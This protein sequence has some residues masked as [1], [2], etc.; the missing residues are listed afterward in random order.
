MSQRSPVLAAVRA[1]LAGVVSER[2]ADAVLSDEALAQVGAL[3]HA[4]PDPFADPEIL[5]AAGWFY[6]YRARSL[7]ANAG[8]QDMEA[9]L[10]FLMPVYEAQPDAVPNRLRAYLDAALSG[11]LG[12]DP[13]VHLG[14]LLLGQAA[15]ADRPGIL[16]K[17]IDLLRQAV[18]ATSSGHPER[19]RYLSVL[20][21]ALQRRFQRTGALADLDEAVDVGRQALAAAPPGHPYHVGFLSNLGNAL[22]ARFEHAG[23]HADLEEAVKLGRQAVA[24]MAP[25]DPNRASVMSN[26][27]GNLMPWFKQTGALADLD[28]AIATL[29]QAAAATPAG[30]A[31]MPGFLSNLGV[32]LQTRFEHTG[33]LADLDESIAALHRAAAVTPAGHPELAGCLSNFAGA[34]QAR[35]E[36]TGMPA[37][38]DDAIGSARQA[39]S[40]TPPGHANRGR[41]L[42]SLGTILMA[43]YER[44]GDLSDLNDAVAAF[45]QVT[46]TTAATQPDYASRVSKLGELLRTRFGRT[47]DL[48]DL[49]EAVSALRQAADATPHDHPDYVVR[50][51]NLAALLQ[52]RFREVGDM[53]DLHDTLDIARQA[54]AAAAP[55]HPERAAILSNFSSAMLASYERTGDPAELD[56]AIEAGRQAVAAPPDDPSDDDRFMPHS[57]LGNALRRRFERTGALTDLNEAIDS[58]RHAVETTPSDH[59]ERGGVLCNLG[60]I[61]ARRYER[62]GTLADLEEDIALVRQ[63]VAI[64]PPG[65]P[66]HPVVLSNLGVG[67]FAR[68]ERTEDVANLEEAVEVDRQA[69]AATPGGHLDRA[70][71][72]SSLGNALAA[73]FERTGRHADLDEAVEFGRQAVAA[74]P[75][76]HPDLTRYLANL[77]TS[78]WSRARNEQADADLDE[79]I[80]LAKLA[81]GA[82]DPGH[83]NRAAFLVNL[84]T[85]LEERFE[86]TQDDADLE[87]AIKVSSE[88]AKTAAAPPHIRARAA[89]TWGRAAA[90]GGR[91]AEAADGFATAVELLA[92]VAP[93]SLSRS[94]QEYWLAEL[95]GLGRQAAACCLQAGQTDRAVELWEQGRGILIAQTLETR[96]DLTRLA[97]Q[98]PQLAAEFIGLRDSLDRPAGIEVQMT[99]PFPDIAEP[100]PEPSGLSRE[101]DRRQDLAEK[102]DR[103]IA[104]IRLLPGL[105][106]F[107]LP[108]L[109]NDLLSAADQGPVVLLNVSAIRSDALL[110]T[111]AGLHVVPLP[112]ITPRKVVDQV[113]TF[114][115]SLD[116]VQDL[117]AGMSQRNQAEGRLMGVLTWMWDA[118]AGPV[119]DRLRTIE[120]AEV[121]A[122]AALTRIWWCPSGLLAFLPLHAAGH[123]ATRFDAEP[124]T[125]MDQ[126]ISSYTPTIRALMHARRPPPAD[127]GLRDAEAGRIL[128]VAMPHTPEAGDLPGAVAEAIALRNLFP[129]NVAVLHG[130]LTPEEVSMLAEPTASS[131]DRRAEFDR[132]C[133][134]LP[135]FPWAHFACHA[136]SDLANPS[137]SHL[138][139]ADY[140]NHP[141]T[142]TDLARLQ[143]DNVELAFLSA[144]ATARTGLRLAD[145]A[146]QL[147]AAFQ[148]AGY[149]HVVATLWP[150]GDRAAV[151]IA[152]DFYASLARH[153]ESEAGNVVARAL[154]EATR[155]YRDSLGARQ[156]WRW[157]AHLHSGA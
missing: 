51:S 86:R 7:G 110:L 87:N 1:R 94:D 72:F 28:E 105:D 147:A 77:S 42:T 69:L 43:R 34:L 36:R 89:R 10:T 54:I 68:F 22:G 56:R 149:R 109:V 25:G 84:G 61:L 17:A 29:R 2:D 131:G 58:L 152:A 65:H 67:L 50:L 45:R 141:L 116:E 120:P 106:R 93:R 52:A 154:R 134:M 60:G 130:E 75:P 21:G 47:A 140:K 129:G 81:A 27:G 139:L 85:F 64:T 136:A 95:A 122:G 157:A 133:T 6:W 66:S 79:A 13:L 137:A 90:T 76:D 48:T 142:V 33:V 80:E 38:L 59:P 148:L 115:T 99:P 49:S 14:E 32:A 138:L 156:P 143:L 108:P 121:G 8:G 128:V 73:L 5:H 18:A 78:L 16:N 118:L 107:L 35:F 103:L 55:D 24:A 155:R 135:L 31:E 111:K 117:N 40:A 30:H 70:R 4:V 53:A 104:D 153:A 150:I 82:V 88:A 91:W 44:T 3:L 97:E 57:N 151:D 102:F 126:V 92:R 26:L 23:T 113:E 144:C 146:I 145:E 124:Q 101:I 127:L 83:P 20:D 71:R 46:A 39:V 125:V 132:V 74:T 12:P 114:V 19:A 100:P 9:A 98:H 119:L 62:T 37:D 11:E 96:S 41:V 112:E 63:A 15:Q 123:H